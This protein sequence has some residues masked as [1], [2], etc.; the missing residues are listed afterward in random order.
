[1]IPGKVVIV[2]SKKY[3]KLVEITFVVLLVNLH[4]IDQKC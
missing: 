1:M 4:N 2:V 3:T